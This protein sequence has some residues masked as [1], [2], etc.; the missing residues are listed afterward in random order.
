MDCSSWGY[1]VSHTGQSLRRDSTLSDGQI[2]ATNKKAQDSI[3]PFTQLETFQDESDLE[4]PLPSS[5][6]LP[7]GEVE[8]SELE[9]LYTQSQDPAASY[10][11]RSERIRIRTADRENVVT[12]AGEAYASW[13]KRSMV[14]KERN[15]RRQEII[16]R[17]LNDEDYTSRY[18]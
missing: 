13:K 1:Q 15:K 17:I 7:F 5:R 12:Q 3:Y 9:H 6:P 16:R 10:T 14:T 8:V 18:V 4:P 11:R 2:V